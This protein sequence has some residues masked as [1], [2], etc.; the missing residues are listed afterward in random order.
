MIWTDNYLN[1]LSVDG[2]ERVNIETPLLFHRFY[3]ATT[4][5]TS[6]YTLPEKVKSIKRITW[7]GIKLDPISWTE[8]MSIFPGSVFADPSEKIETSQSVPYYYFQHPTNRQDI[9]LLPTP[10]ESLLAIGGDPYSPAVDES[11]CIISCWRYV[12]VTDEQAS[13]PSYIDQRIRKAYVL[14]KAYAK[15]GKGQ[16][17]KASAYWESKFNFLLALFKEINNC[18]FV[19]KK[20][21]L[22]PTS[23]GIGR[24]PAKPVLPSNFEKVNYK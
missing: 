23:Y 24:R 6:T 18:V 13:L 12:D 8:A 10:N 5:G 22:D 19:S 15:E 1:Q 9:R 4:A 3:L 14:W 20:Y 21:A 16:D 11:R 2:A 17:L 7:R